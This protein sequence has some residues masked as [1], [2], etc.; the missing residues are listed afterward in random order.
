[1]NITAFYVF[2]CVFFF[3]V[4]LTKKKLTPNA[5]RTGRAGLRAG[6]LSASPCHMTRQ[7][8][9]WTKAVAV[10]QQLV[11][12]FSSRRFFI[13]K[14]FIFFSFKFSMKDGGREVKNFA[15]VSSVFAKLMRLSS[16]LQLFH[17]SWVRQQ[18]GIPTAGHQLQPK[19]PVGSST[20]KH[21]PQFHSS[22]LACFCACPSTWRQPQSPQV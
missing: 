12:F 19:C 8:R 21:V 13:F 16:R 5:L 6:I 9:R 7:A 1:M 20:S 14:I 3:N 4:L 17:Q 15:R 22:C 11:L 18:T 2:Q 10:W